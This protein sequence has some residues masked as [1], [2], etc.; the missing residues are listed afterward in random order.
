[1]V[2]L[3]KDPGALSFSA[4]AKAYNARQITKIGTPV[5]PDGC[6]SRKEDG[7]QKGDTSKNGTGI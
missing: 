2:T 1:M 6:T 5:N 3:G 7:A 4:K